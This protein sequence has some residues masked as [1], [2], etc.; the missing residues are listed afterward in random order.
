MPR[1]W[2]EGIISEVPHT[3]ILVSLN[4]VCNHCIKLEII[5][6]LISPRELHELFKTTGKK[7]PQTEKLP[8]KLDCAYMT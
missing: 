5:C 1:Q 8:K 6:S 2:H 4:Q 7:N 3:V